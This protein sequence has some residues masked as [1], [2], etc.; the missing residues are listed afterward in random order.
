MDGILI[1][2]IPLLRHEA[3]IARNEKRRKATILV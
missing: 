2:N 3:K 1:G